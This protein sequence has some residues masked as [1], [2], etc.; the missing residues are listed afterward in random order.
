MKRMLLFVEK[1][2]VEKA[3]LEPLHDLEEW[4]CKIRL[5]GEQTCSV[6]HRCIAFDKSKHSSSDWADVVAMWKNDDILA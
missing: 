2:K 6:L 5:E 1:P 4:D 3:V